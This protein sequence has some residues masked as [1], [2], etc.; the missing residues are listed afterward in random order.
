MSGSRKSFGNISCG[1][2]F[3]D[4]DTDAWLAWKCE[5]RPF[6]SILNANAMGTGKT[7]AMFLSVVFYY[8]DLERRKAAGEKVVARVR[9]F[10][11]PRFRSCINTRSKQRRSSGS[12]STSVSFTTR[13][14]RPLTRSRTWSLTGINFNRS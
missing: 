14:V 1:I 11:W 6:H 9:P 10:Y 12:F 2:Y 4:N 8:R 7:V 5:G 13:R 3:A